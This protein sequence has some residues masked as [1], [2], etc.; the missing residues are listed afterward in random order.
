MQERERRER[1]DGLVLELLNQPE[2]KLMTTRCLLCKA[3]VTLPE[4]AVAEFRMCEACH[5]FND[6]VPPPRYVG[7]LG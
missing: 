1:L 3:A 7:T 6:Q 2:E 5:D 4:A